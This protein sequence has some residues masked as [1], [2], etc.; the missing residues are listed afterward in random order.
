M[1]GANSIFKRNLMDFPSVRL[2]DISIPGS[3]VL[4]KDVAGHENSGAIYDSR[5]PPR[6]EYML[7]HFIAARRVSI[8]LAACH[9][10]S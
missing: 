9:N 8:S 1:M 2:D 10:R 6:K 3:A 4:Y 5:K 7:R